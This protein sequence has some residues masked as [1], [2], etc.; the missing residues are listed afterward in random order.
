MTR[1]QATQPINFAEMPPP[2]VLYHLA[3]GYYVSRALY[4]A[5]ELGIADH[6]SGGPRDAA[7][8]ARLT[9]T[10]AP[11]LRRVLRLL[12]SAGVFREQED[13]TF[14]LTGLS[15]WLRQDAPS[16]FRSA[17]LLFSGPLEWASWGE[18]MHTVRTGEMALRH[19]F[20][21]DSFEY[22]ESHPEEGKVFDDAMA[23]FTSM[24]AVAVA[25]ACDFTPFRTVVD[26]GGGNG[27]LLIGILEANPHLRGIVFELP[28]AIGHARQRIA[29]AKLDERCE[30]VGG[31]FFEA[32]PGG[33]D[34]YLIKHVIHDWD[35]TQATR[36]L[37][38]IHR[39]MGP[40]ARLLLVEGVYPERID[41][42]IA[43]RGAAL[44]DVN[45]LV[46]T[47]GRQ[48]SEAEF[49]ELFRASGF[50]L[51]RIVPTLSGSCVIEGVRRAERV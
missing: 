2:A 29:A 14:A 38:S 12:A 46:V 10:H 35:D 15:E 50:E 20:G 24:A 28:R 7:E 19:V 42:S 48:R 23:S 47:G 34:A 8:L 18:L 41:G 51:A 9:A 22:L 45:M 6:L 4:V 44:N 1:T 27:A 37:T 30:A 49:R 17:A 11:S 32:V 33:G 31:D 36:I 43:S 13:G 26:V 16:S 21:V 5:V 40:E 3:T 39:A 25:A